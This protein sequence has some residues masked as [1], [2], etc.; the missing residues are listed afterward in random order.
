MGGLRLRLGAVLTLIHTLGRTVA[1]PQS[2]R[3][4]ADDRLPIDPLG[5]VEGSD[6]IV[7]GRDLADVRPQPSVPHPPGDLTQLR[8]IGHDNE[9]DRQ[10]VGRPCLGR[11]GDGY[12]H[13]SG[14]NQTRGP[15]SDV[16]AE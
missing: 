13:S 15:F 3:T 16:A 12:Q 14:S 10:T 5:R 4:N 7:D 1:V 9:V 2:S 6:S 8:A 11:T